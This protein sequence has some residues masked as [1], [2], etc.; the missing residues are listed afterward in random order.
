MP[1]Q[2]QYKI[3]PS[4][5]AK[6]KAVV[7]PLAQGLRKDGL[8][9]WFDGWVLK[10]GDSIP[11]KNEGLEHSRVRVTCMS[12]NALG[13]DLAQLESGTLQTQGHDALLDPLNTERRFLS[14]RF[15][16]RWGGGISGDVFKRS[17]V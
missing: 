3:F 10:P 16:R 4:H 12:A 7:R 17:R 1:E 13:S 6:D 14:R 5:S 11:A 8:K 9:M 15:L 2:F